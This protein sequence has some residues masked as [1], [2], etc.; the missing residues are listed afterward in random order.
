MSQGKGERSLP[1]ISFYRLMRR[2]GVIRT[3]VEADDVTELGTVEGEEAEYPDPVLAWYVDL[4]CEGKK[5]PA[6]PEKVRRWLLDH[7]D[8]ITKAFTHLADEVRAGIDFATWMPLLWPVPEAPRGVRMT[9]ACSAT[10]RTD[11]LAIA[12]VL[13]EM[14]VHWRQW[15]EKMP[16]LQPA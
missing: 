13:T 2:D 7:A 10:R 1:K 16:V 6:G 11:A 15:L 4:R 3:G 12:R 9:I 5:L 8:V 14:A